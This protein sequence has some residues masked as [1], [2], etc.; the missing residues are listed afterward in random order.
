M[1]AVL[2]H[3]HGGPE[4]LLYDDFPSPSI[5]HSQ[6]LVKIKAVALN[7]L[8]LFVR[9]GIP[10]LKLE[11]PHI[12]GSDIA[13]E[14]VE[15]G[16]EVSN[17]DQGQRV[18]IDPGLYCGYCQYC[19]RGEHSLCNRY[20]IIG[21]HSRGGYAEFI[22]V[23]NQNVIPIP[24]YSP[25]EFAEAAATPLT[26]M[27]AWRLLITR[28]DLKPGEDVLITGIGGGV[29]L[30]ALQ[31]AKLVGARVFVTSS[32]DEKLQKALKLGADVGINY[33]EHPDYHT[34]IWQ[35]TNKQGVDVVV[36]SAGQATWEK[37]I[38]TLRKGGR[39]V[40]CGATTGPVAN[41]NI[42][43]LFW[44]QLSLYGSTMANRSELDA[45][46]KLI[47]QNQL[48]PIVDRMFPLKDA[49]KAHEYLENGK[50]FGKVI[51]LP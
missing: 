22:A 1:K 15:I 41:I 12:L 29:A 6:V 2:L 47:W 32:S 39:F 21:E 33:L 35:L 38:R 27:T 50:Q 5:N 8:D 44:K 40:T 14:V 36:D 18:I 23:N 13:G 46:L 7:R 24:D 45:V 16:S 43:L 4:N 11:L 42:N 10:N 30:A 9:K 25:L 49:Q 48:R 34:Q 17:L 31:I 51:L 3:E 19:V 37:S 20:G 26:F 28:A